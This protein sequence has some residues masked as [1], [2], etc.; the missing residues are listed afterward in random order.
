MIKFPAIIHFCIEAFMTSYPLNLVPR[1]A[2]QKNPLLIVQITVQITSA[3]AHSSEG[4][5]VIQG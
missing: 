4:L 3:Y 1:H 2:A 5:C